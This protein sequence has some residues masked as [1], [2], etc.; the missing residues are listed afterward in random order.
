MTARSTIAHFAGWLACR[1]AV[2]CA[3]LLPACAAGAESPAGGESARRV[4]VA[5]QK[6]A[7]Y[8]VAKQSPD[9]AWRSETYGAMRDG[10]SLT[11][12]VMS[13][14]LFLPQAGAG[15]Q[16]ALGN[17]ADYLAGFAGDD[18]RL[19]VQARE[20]RF[21]VYTAASACRVLVLVQRSPRNV[22]AQQAWLA[23]LRGR[24]LDESLGWLPADP[25]YGGWG[26]ALDVPRKPAPGKPK[27]LLHESNLAATV[28]ALAAL[29]SAKVPAG[30]PAYAKALR[31]VNRCQNFSD[32]PAAADAKFDDGGFF[33]IPGDAAQ[34][35]AGA[36]GADRFGRERFHSYGTMTAD[37][38]RAL[39]RCGLAE[40]HPRAVAARNWLTQNF[41]AAH[42]PGAFADDRA[43]LQDAT[44]YYWT[45]AASHA[46]LAVGLQRFPSREGS[47]TWPE[48]FAGELL[49]RQRPDGSW[50]NR[51]TDAKE[52]DPL[53]A[54]AWAS[55]ALA[56]GRAMTCG[57]AGLPGDRCPVGARERR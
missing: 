10:P 14:L 16:A 56:I 27:E 21:P 48:A 15:G 2:V 46:F 22:R 37:G 30:D 35:K 24:Q 41:S 9:G 5:L 19:K 38:L 43:V 44:W 34:N 3:I 55:A 32:D 40:N 20:L 18:G 17:G 51:Y 33:F 11:P 26:Y 42:N 53:V 8:L 36:A 50:V 7:R 29:R 57:P 23:C 4:D 31:F 28:F 52:D 6:A 49:A 25:E 13:A 45:W 12:L 1:V 54:T 39:L 47:V